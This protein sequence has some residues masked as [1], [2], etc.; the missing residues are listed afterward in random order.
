MNAPVSLPDS[1]RQLLVSRHA[2]V[3]SQPPL[4]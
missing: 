3:S 1:K 4:A 2:P